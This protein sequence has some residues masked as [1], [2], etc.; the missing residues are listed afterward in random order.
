MENGFQFCNYVLLNIVNN[1]INFCILKGGKQ[2]LC[3]FYWN[4]IS[5]KEYS[6]IYVSFRIT[7]PTLKCQEKYIHERGTVMRL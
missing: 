5:W 1:Y 2:N 7:L 4:F 3:I 6:Y